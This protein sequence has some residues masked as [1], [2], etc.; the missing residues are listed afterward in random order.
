MKLKILSVS[1]LV[2]FALALC[3]SV[4][5]NSGVTQSSRTPP[6]FRQQLLSPRPRLRLCLNPTPRSAKRSH[7]CVGRRTTWSTPPMILAGTAW[8]PSRPPMNPSASFRIV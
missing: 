3:L 1:A 7:R 5:I 2:I 4:T 6:Q 8:K